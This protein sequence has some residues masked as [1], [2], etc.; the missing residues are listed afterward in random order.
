MV[1]LASTKPLTHVCGCLSQRTLGGGMVCYLSQFTGDSNHWLSMANFIT[2]KVSKVNFS[3]FIVLICRQTQIKNIQVHLWG[4]TEFKIGSIL[5]GTITY[6]NPWNGRLGAIISEQ[7]EHLNVSLLLI[8][9][10]TTLPQFTVGL[11]PLHTHLLEI[12]EVIY[13]V[14]FLNFELSHHFTSQLTK[15]QD[16]CHLRPATNLLLFLLMRW[17]I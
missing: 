16:I 13:G 12:N 3:H 5:W 8:A 6:F 10:L 4:Q 14:L 1:S 7:R 15:S 11:T 17:K 9:V 2:S